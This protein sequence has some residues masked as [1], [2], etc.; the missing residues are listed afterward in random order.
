MDALPGL[1]H[2][3]L[4]DHPD[5][6]REYDLV[7]LLK[8]RGIAPFSGCDLSD[9]L[10]L[11]RTHFRLF[12]NLYLLQGALRTR[13]EGDVAIH[14]LSIRLLP[15][16]DDR[17]PEPVDPLRG[18]YLDLDRLAGTTREEV[19]VML[20]WFWKRFAGAQGREE[21]LTVLGLAGDATAAGIRHRYRELAKIHHPD[22]GGEAA[23][24]RAIT[25]AYEL[26]CGM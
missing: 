1:L 12:H 8:R 14:C 24:F 18:Y 3:I 19:K 23:S 15:W 5:G 7:Q 21:A 20:E 22:R 6:L 17:L 13:Q 9:E 10:N 26:L 25:E 4:R 11:F 2:H 16:R